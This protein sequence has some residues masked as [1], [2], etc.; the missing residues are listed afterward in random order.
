MTPRRHDGARI[1]ARCAE[2]SGNYGLTVPKP[3]ASAQEWA[4]YRQT[5]SDRAM[6]AERAEWKALLSELRAK[7]SPEDGTVRALALLIQMLKGVANQLPQCDRAADA[8]T[9]SSYGHVVGSALSDRT[10]ARLQS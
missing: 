8:V 3:D 4:A 5:W 9:Q 7:V 2:M 10:A 6:A 1:K